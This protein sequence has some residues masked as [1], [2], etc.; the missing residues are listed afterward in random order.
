MISRTSQAKCR[1]SVGCAPRRG[2]TLIELLLVMALIV[3]IGAL[4]LPA[5]VTPLQGQRLRKA[6]DAVRTH[7]AKARIQAMQDGQIYVFQYELNGT[8]YVIEPWYSE[9]DYI[10]GSLATRQRTASS[11]TTVPLGPEQEQPNRQLPEGVMFAGGQ[12]ETTGRSV[13]IEQALQ[14]TGTAQ[15]ILFYPDGTTSS[16][17][18]VLM[19]EQQRAIVV[20][21]RGLTGA[22]DVSEVTTIDQLQ[23]F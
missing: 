2:F 9:N 18:I 5:L 4:T 8:Q 12:V 7:W 3:A 11:I 22:T 6:A 15:P 10:E 14:H 17:E 16:A 1:S 20:Q 21:L 13:V 23:T 19:N